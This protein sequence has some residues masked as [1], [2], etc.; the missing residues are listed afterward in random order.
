[1]SIKIKQNRKV[2]II[3][4][5]ADTRLALY[6]IRSLG[7]RG[8]YI[9][10]LNNKKDS[11]TVLGFFS[12]Y[13]KNKASLI[14]NNKTEK[15]KE[16]I[17]LCKD[18]DIIIPISTRSI[19]FI[20]KHKNLLKKH[21]KFLIPDSAPFKIASDKYL[22]K[23]IALKNKIFT[24][25]IYE[26]S[27]NELNKKIKDINFPVVIKFKDEKRNIYWRPQDRYV[28]VYN[29]KEFI[30]K[31]NE[32]NKIGKIL[33]EE[34]I[35]GQ[36]YGFSALF[37]EKSELKAFFC[38]KRLREYPVT[39]GPSTFCQSIKDKKLVKLG[40]KILKD[41]NWK[42]V[43]MV[44]FKLDN[45][46]NK[47]KLL[48]INPRFWGSL[49]LAIVSGVDFPNLIVDSILNKK[50][51]IQNYKSGV[52]LKFIIFDILSVKD[53][54]LKTKNFKFLFYYLFEFFD[55]R[56]K[57][58]IFSIDDPVPSFIYIYARITQSN[59]LRRLKH[60]IS[61]GR[62]EFVHNNEKQKDLF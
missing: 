39:G 22:T 1:M 44:E 47:F 50:Y 21:I 6:V 43:A 62:S 34:Y 42:G 12:K 4:T 56:I 61:N 46:D 35:S 30:K 23:K 26:I 52:K 51:K 48:E 53:I 8:Y 27:K 15:L 45:K 33:V 40:E 18:H 13:T 38:H 58:G 36:G 20:N 41:L 9:T 14:G 16:L 29:K 60:I 2:K 25:K 49:P 7:R 28:I 19:S 5:D 57:E 11:G 24:P 3:V 37:D 54:F 32:F 59:L 10:A 17:E 31:F 55:F